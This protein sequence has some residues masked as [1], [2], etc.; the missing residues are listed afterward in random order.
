MATRDDD[1]RLPSEL[2]EIADEIRESRHEPTALELDELK[3]RARRKAEGRR[4]GIAPWRKRVLA[5]LLA[6]GLMLSSATGVVVAGQSLGKKPGKGKPNFD[7]LGAKLK[8]PKK[9]ASESQYCP[10]TRHDDSDSDSARDRDSDSDCDDSDSDR[11][12]GGRGDD[13]D[14]DRPRGGRGGDSDSD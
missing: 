7:K 14:S 3:R 11:P 4:S 2:R 12:R 10:S 8:K 1:D 6:L 9:D 5:G 13:S